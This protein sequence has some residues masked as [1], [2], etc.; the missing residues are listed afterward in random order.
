MEKEIEYFEKELNKALFTLGDVEEYLESE[1]L[2]DV[3][4]A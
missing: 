2:D 3:L 1:R 4:D